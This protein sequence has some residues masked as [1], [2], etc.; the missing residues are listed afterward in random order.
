MT[1]DDVKIAEAG[2]YLEWSQIVAQKLEKACEAVYG[3]CEKTPIVIVYQPLDTSV[4]KSTK[5]NFDVRVLDDTD[6]TFQWQYLA[7]TEGASWTNSGASTGTTDSLSFTASASYTGYKYRCKI[8]KG[9]NVLYSDE[10]TLTV[11]N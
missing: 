2:R 8:T 9:S 5:C 4:K 10:A 3:I 1:I 11:T 7:T 6:V